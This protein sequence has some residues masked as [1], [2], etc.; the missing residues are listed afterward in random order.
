MR[1]APAD[2]PAHEGAMPLGD[3]EDGRRVEAAVGRVGLRAASLSQS[4]HVSEANGRP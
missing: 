1:D 2:G 4:E 3:E